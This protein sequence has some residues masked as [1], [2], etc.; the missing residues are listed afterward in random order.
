MCLL[1]YHSDAM[2]QMPINMT[3][4]EH[5]PAY[6]TDLEAS[7]RM[8]LVED[9]GTGDV[10]ADLIAADTQGSAKVYVREDA[11]LC[12]TPWFNE[13]FR[14]VDPSVQIRWQHQDGDVVHK[15]AVLCEISGNARSM[16]TAER[17][18]LNFLQ[19]LSA[20]ATATARYVE[21]IRHTKAQM[22]D[23]RK[24]IPGLRNAQKYA[25]LC[26]GGANHRIGLYDRVLIKENHIMAA[27]SIIA[28]VQQAKRLHPDVLVEVETENLDEFAE[29][30]AAQA[31]I[32]MLDNFDNELLREAVQRNAGKIA[33]EASGGVTLAT[34]TAIAETGV[35]FISVGEITKHVRAVDLSMRFDK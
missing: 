4:S 14:Q 5:L 12:G 11:L 26:G 20:T 16:L 27:G 15:D 33:L 6:V 29:A 9:I 28:A 1:A 32:I 30:S 17:A 23:T 25:V 31:D 18:A 2:K 3:V 19:L 24:T 8:A 21:Q 10:T 22:L 13:V 7:V 35:D 34:V